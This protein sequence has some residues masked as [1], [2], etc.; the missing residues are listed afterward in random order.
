MSTLLPMGGNLGIGG[1]SIPYEAAKQLLGEDLLGNLECQSKVRDENEDDDEGGSE[2]SGG[3]I[4]TSAVLSPKQQQQ[5][6]PQ[7]GF[8]DDLFGH[9]IYQGILGKYCRTTRI[10]QQLA[11]VQPNRSSKGWTEYD[12]YQ[13]Q[14]YDHSSSHQTHEIHPAAA[15]ADDNFSYTHHNEK[16]M[17]SCPAVESDNNL[18]CV[19]KVEQKC[20]N[21]D[22]F[23]ASKIAASF[24]SMDRSNNSMNSGRNCGQENVLPWFQNEEW[25]SSFSNFEPSTPVCQ[26]PN[27]IDDLQL[28]ARVIRG[29]PS[30]PSAA[31]VGNQKPVIVRVSNSN[32]PTYS[33]QKAASRAI[34]SAFTLSSL[35]QLSTP[36][37][38]ANQDS[39]PDSRNSLKHIPPKQMLAQNLEE[40]IR[41][42]QLRSNFNRRFLSPDNRCQVRVNQGD[43]AALAAITDS[44]YAKNHRGSK[45]PRPEYSPAIIKGVRLPNKF[46]FNQNTNNFNKSNSTNNN[47]TYNDDDKL[48]NQ[49]DLDNQERKNRSKSSSTNSSSKNE[50]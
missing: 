39:L 18:S 10:N 9:Q 23:Y 37:K 6:Q 45:G 11:E 29:G 25:M 24:L 15:A 5:Q 13:Q 40:S 16:R 35:H 2:V 44:A 22:D 4:F 8:D 49:L 17:D 14:F 28:P 3:T 41:Q 30:K 42:R 34:F 43:L 33:Q 7:L 47:I 36:N 50:S 12:Y 20:S 1:N 27:F 21:V 38:A 46:N 19:Q 31:T 32:S 48:I 26:P